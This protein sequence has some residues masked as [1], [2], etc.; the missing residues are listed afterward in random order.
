M[1]FHRWSLAATNQRRS[2]RFD[3]A[4]FAENLSKYST[5]SHV[6]LGDGTQVFSS[7]IIPRVQRFVVSSR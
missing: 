6:N 2:S 3:R 1:M 4:F 5:A 7:A